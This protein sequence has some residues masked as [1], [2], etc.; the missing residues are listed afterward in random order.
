MK[1]CPCKACSLADKPFLPALKPRSPSLCPGRAPA[2]CK[3]LPSVLRPRAFSSLQGLAAPR[4]WGFTSFKPG[5][6]GREHRH[7]AF[8]ASSSFE[9]PGQH[10]QGRFV[11]AGLKLD[12][13]LFATRSGAGSHSFKPGGLLQACRPSLDQAM[14]CPILQACPQPSALPSFQAKDLFNL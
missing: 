1:P 9:G 7:R 3:H 4:S 11:L 10:D 13:G 6:P 8:G 2:F 12:Q 14:R 5:A